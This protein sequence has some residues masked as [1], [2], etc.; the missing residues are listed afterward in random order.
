MK[1][2]QAIY[3]V[4][5]TSSGVCT[6]TR[7]LKPGEL[8]IALKGPNFNGNE[9]AQQALD[10][11][12]LAAIID[13]GS[14]E[15]TALIRVTDGL[16]TLQQLAN[17][18]RKQFSLPVLAIT[19]SNG[20]TTTR[21]LTGAVLAESYQ[22]LTTQGNLN[23]H[24]GVPLTILQLTP[25]HE[26]AVVEMGANQVGDIAGYCQIAEPTHGLITNIGKAH[27]EGFG[28]IEGI[29]RGKSELYDYLIK[30]NGTG[31]IPLT[32]P[33]LS[34]MKKRFDPEYLVTFGPEDANYPTLEQTTSEFLE[35]TVG[36]HRVIVQLAG[37]YNLNNIAA[38]LAIGRYFN[39]PEEAMHR[40][41]SQ[42]IPV[43]NRSQIL[44]KGDLKII[45]D[46]YNANPTSMTSA[47][48][49]LNFMPESN[50]SVIL[51]DMLEL[52]ADSK[53]EHE[54]LAAKLAAMDLREIILVGPEMTH[55][56]AALP[57][58]KYA[59][60]SSELAKKDWLRELSPGVLLIKG[61]RG[62][63]L[64]KVLDSL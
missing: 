27:L 59:T 17:Y 3:E 40:A 46:A 25:S 52:G 51:G 19:G 26:V 28:G 36:E 56:A 1:D 39:V 16:Q 14:S 20:K 9:F 61:S 29:I 10:K 49:H 32:D 53:K 30:H 4:F 43:E 50:K 41:I 23:N 5:L 35:Y 63:A 31:F 2:I 48:D 21:A 47:L 44:H 55:A 15:S 24:I 7:K 8:Y 58:A 6:D 62:M 34:N 22:T 18:H 37:Q 38:A 11:G 33:I 42:F 60:S 64:E 12:A 13:E 57:Q 54:A 45:L